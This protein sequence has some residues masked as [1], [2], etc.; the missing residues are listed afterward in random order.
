MTVHQHTFRA[1]GCTHSVLTTDATTL[2]AASVVAE[3]MVAQLDRAASRFRADSQLSRITA[4]A[5]DTDVQVVVSE[6]LG[7]CLEPRCTPPISPTAWST[8]R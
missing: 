4:A 5:T 1:I 3:S 6:L 2:E 8:R 7:G